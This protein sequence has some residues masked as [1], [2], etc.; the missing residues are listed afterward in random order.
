MNPV[1]RTQENKIVKS[2]IVERFQKL[3][4]QRFNEP[5]DYLTAELDLMI[6]AEL[7]RSISPKN[8]DN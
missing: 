8:E 5:I 2:Y 6:L 1:K 7:V 4:Q 3:H